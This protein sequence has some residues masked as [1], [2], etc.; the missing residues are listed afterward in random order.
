MKAQD[1]TIK[2]WLTEIRLGKLALPRFQRFE[3]WGPTIIS[4]FLTSIVRGLPVGVSLILEVG[5][6]PQFKYRYFLGVPDQRESVKALLLDGQQR[7]TALWRS[8][9]DSY[10]DKT[11]LLDLDTEEDS[12]IS[13]IVVS[14]WISKRK[15]KKYPL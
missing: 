8:F 11:Y 10:D 3:T 9:I 15:G 13:A 2:D 7:L 1:R 6:A 14:R 12:D 5:S 4:D